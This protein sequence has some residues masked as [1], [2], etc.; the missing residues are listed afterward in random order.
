MMF[1]IYLIVCILTYII[2]LI[3]VEKLKIHEE[4]IVEHLN[5]DFM[6][7]ISKK[8]D[9]LKLS[10]KLTIIIVAPIIHIFIIIFMLYLLFADIDVLIKLIDRY[11]KGDNNE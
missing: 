9:R 6:D 11:S 4:Y 3:L 5:I 2:M 10:I 8:S 1:K 7:K